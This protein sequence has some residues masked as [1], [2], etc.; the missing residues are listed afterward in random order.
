MSYTA[1]TTTTESYELSNKY[2]ISATATYG[3]KAP[4]IGASFSVTLGASVTTTWKTTKTKTVTK[5]YPYTCTSPAGK[6][7]TCKVLY[8]RGRMVVP[9][10]LTLIRKGG[11]Y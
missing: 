9:F 2:S 7:T 11:F 1:T 6:I 10:T 3:S 4:L 8:L 5:T